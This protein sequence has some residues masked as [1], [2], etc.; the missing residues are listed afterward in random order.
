MKLEEVVISQAIVESFYQDFRK[1]LTVEVAIA[2][3]GPAGLTASYY[4]AKEGVKTV[5]FEKSLRVGGGMPGGGMMFNKIVVQ[6]SAKKI[7]EEMNIKHSTYREGYYIADSIEAISALTLKAIRA[8][9]KIFNLMGVEDITI[10]NNRVSGLV[11]N[12]E[13]VRIA[14]LH[15]DPL[16]VSCDIAVDATGHDCEVVKKL[17]QREG[18]KLVTPTGRIVGEGPMW[19]ERGEEQILECTKEVYPGIYVAGMAVNAVFGAAR[20]GPIFGGM[21]LSGEKVAK[22]ILDQIR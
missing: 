8:G 3:A 13:A 12:W 22:A 10:K 5:V 16:T 11:I 1:Y 21:L 4:L 20:M 18:I 14:K 15:V 6:E 9:V 19:A 2:G 7:L 17:Q